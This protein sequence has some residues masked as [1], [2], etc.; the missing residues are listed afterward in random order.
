MVQKAVRANFKSHAT[1]TLSP[2]RSI[3]SAAVIVVIGRSSLDRESAKTV[4]A[5]NRLCRDG[6]SLEV[7]IFF[8]DEL[9]AS[10][11]W[12]ARLIVQSNEIT[13]ASRQGTVSR[14]KI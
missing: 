14:V 5:N 4:V 6:E 7:Q 2:T 9:T 1:G 11:K 10:S 13:V 12:R 3:D 8:P